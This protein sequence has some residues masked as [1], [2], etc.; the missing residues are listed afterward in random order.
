MNKEHSN[1]FDYLQKKS[2]LGNI[3][4]TGFLYPKLN[5]ILRGKVLDLGCGVG[6]FLEFRLGTVG[7]DVN[8]LLVKQCVAKGLEAHLME[9][10]VLPFESHSFDGVIMDNVL[11][12]IQ[13][14]EQTFQEVRRVLRPDGIFLVGVP[15]RCGFEFDTDHKIFYDE[16]L[17]EST[18]NSVGFSRSR[19]FF[20]PFKNSLLNQKMR[21]YCLFGIYF[22]TP[23]SL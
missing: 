18:L 20:T 22:V 19:H 10:G 13:E 17:L 4:R 15:G 9:A 12:H 14:P 7:A 5:R 21:Q 1:Y 6:T 2:R 16:Q 23:E 3:Y 8:P 11:E